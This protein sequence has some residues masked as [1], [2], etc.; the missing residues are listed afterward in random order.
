MINLSHNH[1]VVRF[2]IG[3]NTYENE[4][5]FECSMSFY[6]LSPETAYIYNLLGKFRPEHFK[7]AEIEFKKRGFKRVLAYFPTKF[8][9]RGFKPLGELQ[10]YIIK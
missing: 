9:L 5:P 3:S 2:Y 7:E 8:Q 10:E 1:G 4:D 6:T